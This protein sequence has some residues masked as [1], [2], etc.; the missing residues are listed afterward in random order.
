MEQER[1]L[2]IVYIVSILSNIKNVLCHDDGGLLGFPNKVVCDF[3]FAH[4]FYT[5]SVFYHLRT[6]N[7]LFYF[8]KLLYSLNLTN[9]VTKK[10]NE[11]F[12][13]KTSKTKYA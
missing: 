10:K 8:S 1:F 7:C 13:N 3:K 11:L 2:K 4:K 12:K 5:F 6:E 9:F